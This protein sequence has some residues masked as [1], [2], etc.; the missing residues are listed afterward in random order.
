MTQEIIAEAVKTIDWL[1]R[2]A[3]DAL[4]RKVFL[5]YLSLEEYKKAH[6]FLTRFKLELVRKK[7]PI[8]DCPY[9]GEELTTKTVG[10]EYYDWCPHCEQEIH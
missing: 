4:D 7:K 2:V 10:D 1:M 6:V 8:K 5:Y 9:C 3:G